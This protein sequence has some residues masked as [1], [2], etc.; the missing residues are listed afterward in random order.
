MPWFGFQPVTLPEGTPLAEWPCKY[1]WGDGSNDYWST[2]R[3]MRCF[4]A[5]VRWNN[6]GV[7]I[8]HAGGGMWIENDGTMTYD[9]LI[10]VCEG[11][12]WV[13][14]A[15]SHIPLAT[16][17][18]QITAIP[19]KPE[20]ADPSLHTAL[21]G[22]GDEINEDVHEACGAFDDPD[23]WY[24]GV[25]DGIQPVSD[26]HVELVIWA[27]QREL[28]REL[29]PGG[30]YDRLPAVR[31][32]ELPPRVQRAVVERRRL[33]YREFGINRTDWQ[34]GEWSLWDVPEDR[35]WLPRRAARLGKATA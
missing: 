27:L 25:E 11:V 33:R 20:S 29:R 7:E 34:R 26:E 10:Q 5:L 12:P 6:G 16:R 2:G 31:L 18:E 23:L 32:M 22:L 13:K 15:L 9:T 28:N 1:S 35:D 4:G 8:P 24:P 30:G 21:Q 3:R 19:K 14:F 17:F